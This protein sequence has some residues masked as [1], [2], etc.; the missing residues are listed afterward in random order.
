MVIGCLSILI[1]YKYWS[2][3]HQ[4]SK[5]LPSEDPV[6]YPSIRRPVGDQTT[7]VEVAAK[8]EG[9]AEDPTA[10]GGSWF[11]I[12]LLVLSPIVIP[13][14]LVVIGVK[15]I[16]VIRCDMASSIQSL[17]ITLIHYQH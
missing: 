12:T 17:F 13:V 4:V 5:S 7:E 10:F 6:R 1:G 11:P 14:A 3:T 15:V 8:A 16:Q 2:V 9:E